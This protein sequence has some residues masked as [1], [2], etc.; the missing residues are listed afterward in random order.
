L[1]LVFCVEPFS[2]RA[3]ASNQE[4]KLI[5]GVENFGMP[6]KVTVHLVVF[7]IRDSSLK[8]LLV[9]RTGRALKNRMAIPTAVLSGNES[10][11]NAARRALTTHVGADQLYLE[12]LYCSVDP[13][14]KHTNGS[15]GFSVAYYSLLPSD[16]VHGMTDT[17]WRS[18]KS[19][20]SLSPAHRCIVENALKRLQKKVEHNTAGFRLLS[21]KFT[22]P[23]LQ[24]MYEAI[25]GTTLDK[26]NFRKKMSSLQLLRPLR[27]WRR[28]GR[29]P[30]R[31]YTVA[32]AQLQKLEQQENPTYA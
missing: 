1:D 16:H 28:T 14:K 31:L 20:G 29:K 4:T 21:R 24:G 6:I 27:E 13:N 17:V 2:L 3:K 30:A 15:R 10:F 26:R 18:V 25:L 11:E 22:L 32:A 12:Q 9:S 19:P 8:V 7:T 23:E 5:Q